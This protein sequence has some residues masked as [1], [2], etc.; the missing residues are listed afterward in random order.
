MTKLLEK[1][2]VLFYLFFLGIG[3]L[4]GLIT[5]FIIHV[6]W[7]GLL[8]GVGVGIGLGLMAHGLLMIK[9]QQW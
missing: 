6:I 7:L 9:N 8:M 5:G 4:L 3:L 2:L 1:S